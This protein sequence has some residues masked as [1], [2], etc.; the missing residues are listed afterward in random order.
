MD[1][2]KYPQTTY[3]TKV[4]IGPLL[5]NVGISTRYFNIHFNK[6]WQFGCPRK[7]SRLLS[8]TLNGHLIGRQCD[9]FISPTSICCCT[10]F[11]SEFTISACMWYSILAQRWPLGYDWIIHMDSPHKAL[12]AS[13][14]RQHGDREGAWNNIFFEYLLLFFLKWNSFHS[15]HKWFKRSGVNHFLIMEAL[16]KRFDRNNHSSILN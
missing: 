16:F 3:Y 1:I 15:L 7:I 11:Y 10:I 14:Y 2:N 8:S 9:H 13:R 5:G 12:D 4:E 6:I